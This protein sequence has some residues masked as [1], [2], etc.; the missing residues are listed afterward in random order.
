VSN[1]PTAVWW[2]AVQLWCCVAEQTLLL[3]A[4]VRTA[5]FYTHRRLPQQQ[6]WLRS[7]MRPGPVVE[8][9]RQVRQCRGRDQQ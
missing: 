7:S 9:K 3:Q 5:A 8:M 2:D 6:Q 1:G 4:L